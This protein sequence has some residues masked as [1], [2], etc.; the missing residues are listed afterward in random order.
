[1]QTQG[2]VESVEEKNLE[3]L[4]HPSGTEESEAEE[5]TG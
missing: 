5:E 4:D 1:M 3:S 2:S